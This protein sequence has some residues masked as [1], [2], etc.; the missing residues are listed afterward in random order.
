MKRVDRQDFLV[1]IASNRYGFWIESEGRS[2]P[3]RACVSG[4]MATCGA[5]GMRKRWQG[6]GPD[7]GVGAPAG[8]ERSKP[9]P[10]K[11][12]SGDRV[13]NL[14]RVGAEGSSAGSWPKW[15]QGLVTC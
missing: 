2:R 1:W 5:V 8:S 3:E 15:A 4:H 10:T 14:T 6:R 11:G 7:L 13:G 9:G 12:A